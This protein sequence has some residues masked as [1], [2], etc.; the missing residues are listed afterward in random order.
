MFAYLKPR[1]EAA[2]SLLLLILQPVI[3]Y[4]RT[5][6]GLRSHIPFDIEGYHLGQIG[7]VAQCLRT[8]VAPLWDPYSYAGMPIHADMQAQVFYPPTWLVMLFGN[9]SHGHYLFYWLEWM[10]PA[11]M[12]LAGVVTFILLRR[13]GLGAP[14]ALL[15][16]SVFQLGSFF[17][18]QAQHLCA[19]CSAAWL[20]AIALAIYELR[21][22]F[23]ARWLAVLAVAVAMSILAGFAAATIVIAFAAI[24]FA[25]ALIATRETSW[26]IAG[27]ILAGYTWGALIAAAILIP[28]WTLTQNSI[29]SLRSQW[30][31]NGGGLDL[32]SL[33]SLVIPNYYHIFDLANFKL[34][35]NFTFLY[36][37]C[38]IIPAV[39]IV[40]ALFLPRIKAAVFLG[41]TVLSALWMVGEHAPVY[42]AIFPHLPKLLKG[43]IYAEYAMIAFAFF[44][45]LT[46]A[47]ELDRL[48][49]RIPGMV[50][51]ALVLFTSWDLIHTGWKR[52][53]NTYPG[54][55]RVEDREELSSAAIVGQTFHD[56][57]AKTNPAARFDYLDDAYP[58]GRH[59]AGMMRLPTPDGDNPFMLLRIHRLRLMYASGNPWQRE[60]AV[61]HLNS[62]LLNMLNTSFL[63]SARELSPEALA[64]SGFE[65]VVETFGMHAYRNPRALPRFFLTPGIR[66][67][68]NEDET[69]RLLAEPSFDPAA[70]AIVEGIP[71][72]R[73][74]LAVAPVRVDSWTE[75]RIELNAAAPGPAFLVT[76]EAMFPGWEARVNGAP[77]PILMTNGAFRGLTLAAG[78]SRIVMEYKPASLIPAL[79]ISLLSAVSAFALIAAPQRFVRRPTSESR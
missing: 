50:L 24:V 62:P 40:L 64:K 54:G 70:E 68:A 71:S 78:E 35:Q 34:N 36:T 20:P 57:A 16:A 10:D 11:H 66:K 8:G 41:A 30:T 19:I 32:E 65:P 72:D 28:A 74:Q 31:I 61:D 12:I 37:Y 17:A 47:F 75:N 48:S 2:F 73:Q 77:Q 33:V 44:A 56:L 43:A 13:M 7:Y 76:S 52:P 21:R 15:G 49:A 69:F 60:I 79:L 59:A 9:L 5:V 38:G 4:W 22:G 27:P 58:N 25:L 6:I 23:R 14:T 53:M 18:S 3:F 29:A 67:S 46:A 26:R 55:P 39:L 42:K 51:W 45:A 1:Y 63:A